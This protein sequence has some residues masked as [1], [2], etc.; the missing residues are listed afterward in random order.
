MSNKKLFNKK[1]L[2]FRDHLLG[3]APQRLGPINHPGRNQYLQ[4]LD[5]QVLRPPL[6]Q[7]EGKVL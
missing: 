3:T 1:Q 5:Y 2:N 6:L 7:K 4:Y